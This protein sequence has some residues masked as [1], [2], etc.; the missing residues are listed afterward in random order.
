MKLTPSQQD[1][2]RTVLRDNGVLVGYIFGSYA[3]GTAGTMS[4]LDVGVVFPSTLPLDVQ[5]SRIECMRYAL[6]RTYGRDMVDIINVGKIK[7]PLLRYIIVLGE[8][9]LLYADDV[10]LRNQT[11]VRSLREFEDTR[12]LRN[13]QGVAIRHIFA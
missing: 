1:R 4:D 8:G 3:R 5:E 10:S 7:N 2:I 9:I 12:H 13:I 6:E 11:A